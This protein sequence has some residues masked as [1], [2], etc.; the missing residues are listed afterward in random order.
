MNGVCDDKAASESEKEE[1][2][3]ITAGDIGGCWYI[4]QGEDKIWSVTAAPDFYVAPIGAFSGNKLTFR[5]HD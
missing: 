1:G 2:F 3:D 4:K 5:A